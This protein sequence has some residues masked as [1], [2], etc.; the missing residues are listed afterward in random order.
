MDVASSCGTP[1]WRHKKQMSATALDSTRG[2]INSKGLQRT[3]S[4]Q[5][6]VAFKVG[7]GAGEKEEE[8]AD[9]HQYRQREKN[10]NNGIDETTNETTRKSTAQKRS[11]EMGEARGRNR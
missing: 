11:H 5:S 7:T 1:V 3:K 2:E 8:T 9:S 10:R 6:M 4:P